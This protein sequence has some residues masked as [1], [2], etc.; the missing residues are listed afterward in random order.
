MHFLPL[1][2]SRPFTKRDSKSSKKGSKGRGFREKVIKNLDFCPGLSR[3]GGHQA[4][5]RVSES[6]PSGIGR[7]NGSSKGSGLPF[8][9][10]QEHHTC[11]YDACIPCAGCAS[12]IG[13]ERHRKGCAIINSPRTYPLTQLPT[14]DRKVFRKPN[15]Q[16]EAC[17]NSAMARKSSTIVKVL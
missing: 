4:G 10:R 3:G 16:N 7:E 2:H 9:E 8:R 1:L 17:F 5:T 13:N 6:Y 15:E 11:F 14:Y 12:G